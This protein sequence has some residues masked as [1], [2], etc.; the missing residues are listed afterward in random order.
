MDL[1]APQNSF[2]RDTSFEPDNVIR[3]AMAGIFV[4]MFINQLLINTATLFDSII[5]GRF[6]SDASLACTSIVYQLTFFNITLGSV[7]AVGSQLE[8]SFALARGDQQ[9]ANRIFTAS[10]MLLGII[11]IVFA[12]L[13]MCFSHQA[14]AVIGAPE[15]AGELHDVTSDYIR[16]LSIGL[17]MEYMVAFLASIMPLVGDK[18][19][20]MAASVV[21]IVV[22]V[23]GDLVNVFFLNLGMFGIGL[24]TS[25]SNYCAA[26]VLALH[27][28]SKG[29][30]FRLVRVGG[31]ISWFVVFFKRSFSTIFGR[32]MKWFYFLTMIRILLFM[33]EEADL[34]A[35]SMFNNIRNILICLCLGLGSA[36]L[37]IAGTMY[38][39][40]N[41]RGLRQTVWSGLKY[42]VILGAVIGALVAIF[43]EPILSLYGGKSGL[44]ESVFILRVYAILFFSPFL[45]FYYAY[46]VRGIGDR[47]LTTY[48]NVFGEF[49]IPAGTAMVMGL[50]FGATGI[51]I[52]FPL[53][54][55]I[56]VASSILI[57]R[58]RNGKC[59]RPSDI[60]MLLPQKF[61][62]IQ[63]RCLNVSPKDVKEGGEYAREAHDFLVSRGYDEKTANSVSLCIEESVRILWEQSGPEK[64]SNVNLFA[65]KEDDRIMIRLRSSGKIFDPFSVGIEDEKDNMD[66]TALGA[67]ILRYAADEVEYNTALGVNN[68]IITCHSPASSDLR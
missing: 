39:E 51:W 14:A 30:R 49:I 8:C 66:F 7:F 2:V 18:K 44:Q 16:G 5:I 1:S 17:P 31:L 57:S 6:Y 33:T 24:A 27:F 45:H 53:G 21:M 11:S 9:K 65:I 52:A 54:S 29:N 19:R 15:S 4:A 35:Y 10:I 56:T 67:L 32:V 20:I 50:L 68:I 36:N 26:A 48:F 22:N 40:K 28:L 25:V 55:A 64:K 61:L 12:S 58:I 47:F 60:V 3:K 46:Y 62:D 13:L 34:V 38:E 43:A 41:V 59:R 23:G 37:L 42:S 63:D